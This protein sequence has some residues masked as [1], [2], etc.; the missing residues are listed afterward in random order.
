MVCL[1]VG[2]AFSEDKIIGVWRGAS[3]G[4]GDGSRPPALWEGYP[5][6]GCKAVSWVVRLQGVE[7][8]A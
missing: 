7:G 1:T 4:V 5:G 8:W 2:L 6:N 3:K